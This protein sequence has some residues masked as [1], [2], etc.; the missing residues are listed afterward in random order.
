M[1]HHETYSCAF[2]WL[3]S[4]YAMPD[5]QYTSL[6][7]CELKMYTFDANPTLRFIHFCFDMDDFTKQRDSLNLFLPHRIFIGIQ[8]W[9]QTP[10]KCL[11]MSYLAESYF[12]SLE[13]IAAGRHVLSLIHI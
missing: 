9:K 13:N 1:T 7:F 2:S 4:R 10:F 3:W 12:K 6:D 8:R 11:S 5:Q